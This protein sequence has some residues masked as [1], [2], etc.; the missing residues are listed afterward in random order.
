MTDLT[1]ILTVALAAAFVVVLL[2]LA[3]SIIYYRWRLRDS[4]RTLARFI[5]ENLQL[6][7]VIEKNMD[8]KNTDKMKKALFT[9]AV[10]V[11]AVAIPQRVK[12]YDFS[13]V[14][15][16]GHTLCYNIV[17]GEA[18]V[19]SE[20]PSPSLG[21]R[22]YN[23]LQGHVIV[24][25]SVT[26]NGIT[27]PVTSLGTLAFMY[28]TNL[29]RLTLPATL[30]VIGSWSIA[31]CQAMDSVVVPNTVQVIDTGAFS[32]SFI[33]S[34]RIPD[35]VTVIRYQ[36]F[37]NCYRLRSVTLH[38][39][40]TSIEA[41][42]FSNCQSLADLIIPSTVTIE[43]AATESNGA[44]YKVLHIEYHGNF[45][46]A[47]WGAL[48]MNG[49]REGD[50]IFNGTARD[51][52]V[53][54]I[55][56][57]SSVTIPATVKV[58]NSYCFYE[59]GLTSVTMP[60]TMT[61]IGEDVFQ[62]CKFTEITLPDSLT[63]IGPYAFNACR[64]LTSVTVPNAVTT[65]EDNAFYNCSG[66]TSVTLGAGLRNIGANAFYVCTGVESITIP[67]S[68]ATIG[69]MAFYNVPHIEY[70]GNATGAPWGAKTINGVR[71][72]DFLY[73]D[74]TYTT[75]LAYFGNAGSVTVPDGVTTI[76]AN[77][78][79]GNT[80]LFMVEIPNT[81]TVI[82]GGAFRNCSNLLMVTM[83]NTMDSIGENVFNNCQRLTSIAWP[84]G[85]PIIPYMTFY[86]CRHLSSVQIPST[87]TDIDYYAFYKCESLTSVTLP[88]SLRNLYP[89]T[90]YQCTGLT[91]ITLPDSLL[92]IG[93]YAFAYCSGLISVSIPEG[94]DRI[95]NGL[96]RYCDQLTSVTLPSTLTDINAY[97]FAGCTALEEIT[98]HAL[99][100]PTPV[101]AN[102]SFND[103]DSNIVVNIPCGSI[104]SYQAAWPRFHNFNETS[105]F[106]FS[107]T[108]ADPTMGTV[109]V[110][111]APSCQD[112]AAVVEATP[113]EGNLFVRWNDGNTDNPR[114]LLVTAD[115]H[116]VAYFALSIHDT[117]FV[118]V[119]DTFYVPVHDTTVVTEYIHDTIFIRD[120]VYVGIDGVDAL[121]AK[122]YYN[123]RQIVVEGAEQNTVTLFDING[124]ALATKQDYGAPLRFDVHATGTYLVKIGRHAAR[125]VTVIK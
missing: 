4:H 6:R 56:S 26:Y 49:L 80:N 53:S 73:Y 125:K 62:G 15:P 91:S 95:Y 27:Y 24:P 61:A 106:D 119:H 36:A 45:T 105:F 30:R 34:I 38:S 77:A 65:I 5:R 55:G 37:R 50:F 84:H 96:F 29:N 70:H 42:A 13:A 120:T 97:A 82:E 79:Q 67:D 31:A 63:T 74:T 54:W 18:Q 113:S 47:P 98:C 99:T 114:T 93:N 59:T 28:C 8:S 19:T 10:L 7:S 90:F 1:L 12:A 33:T 116:L 39:G 35:S 66:L 78:F 40:I 81:V 92:Y 117:V 32:A 9:L 72:G 2:L 68:V 22:A 75:I 14:S 48:W 85:V 3:A 86:N 108:S 69:S 104:A 110:L 100:A 107:T 60:S 121:N 57:G 83:P 112:S 41:R 46:G 17:N 11:M 101:A 94:I 20:N 52:L 64:N 16:S 115:S 123:N 109:T 102:N 23:N 103:I 118:P 124:R 58:L 111:T 51:T 44:F 87:V 21:H 76:G 89:Y 71:V 43:S 122:I 88:D 25:D